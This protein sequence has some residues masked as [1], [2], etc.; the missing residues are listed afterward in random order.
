MVVWIIGMSGTGKTT[1]ATEVVE[2]IRRSKSNVVLLDG[3]LIRTLFKN[4][5]DHT[6]NGRRKNAERMSVL[7]KFLADQDINVVAAVLSIFPEWQRWNRE[8]ISEYVE[9]YIKTSMNVLRLRDIKNLY[10][11]A[12]RGEI[13]NVVGVDIPFPEPENPDLVI[14]NDVERTEF[15]EFVDKI[16]SI[17]KVRI[18]LH[19]E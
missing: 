7:S 15:G 18:E 11:R 19:R 4:D 14:E 10:G 5:V 1:V 6:I 8:N 12:E 17:N 13:S 3:D 9:V 16:L 2:N